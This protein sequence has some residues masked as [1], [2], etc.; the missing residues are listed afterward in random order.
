MKTM[1]KKRRFLAALSATLLILAALVTSCMDPLFDETSEQLGGN[2]TKAPA[3]KGLVRISIADTSERTIYPSSLPSLGDMYY[4]VQF[5]SDSGN[6]DDEIGDSTTAVSIGLLNGVSTPLAPDG[7]NILITAW[8]GDDP[9]SDKPLAGWTGY[10]TVASGASTLVTANLI[11][12]TTSGDGTFSYSITVPA[13]PSTWAITTPPTDYSTNKMEVINASNVTVNTVSLTKGTTV[14]GSI[15]SLTAG[16]YTVKITLTADDCQDRVV[17]NA[18]HIYNTMTSSY[19]YNV[20]ALNQDNFSVAFD[21]NGETDTGSSYTSTT[22]YPIAFLG[23]V[24]DPGDPESAVYDFDGWND[25]DDGSGTDWVFGGTGTKVLKDTTLYAQW[26]SKSGTVVSIKAI[27][28]VTAPVAGATPDTAITAT[29]EYTGTITWKETIT[30]TTVGTYFE[31]GKAY[32]ATITLS[33]ESGYIFAGVDANFFTVAGAT[34]VTNAANSGVVTAVFPATASTITNTA[35][36]GV[37]VPVAGATPVTTITDTQYTGVITWKETISGTVLT[38]DFEAGKAYTATITL[39]P[40]DGFTTYGLLADVFTVAGA[41]PVT[42]AANNG[43]VTA[44]FPTKITQSA[45]AGITPPKVGGVPTSTITATSEYTA[46]IS[47]LPTDDPF[48]AD[49]VYIATITITPKTGY[50]LNGVPANFFT[51]SG[52]VSTNAA[53]DGVVTSVFPVTT[54]GITMS[55]TFILN[56]MG[57]SSNIDS[58]TQAQITNGEKK[59]IFT[60]SGGPFDSNSVTWDMDGLS[61]SGGTDIGLTIDDTSNL[62]SKLN[63]GKHVLNV[64]GMIGTQEFSTNIEFTIY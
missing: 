18:M 48:I 8:E 25:K 3:G 13:L 49:V 6:N 5:T 15:P 35:I 45:I 38:G 4:T 12:W 37:T 30:G 23:T 58:A 41:T 55:I 28:G 1:I 32:T 54:S 19:S 20:P 10:A 11:G 47:W 64:K 26:K 16:Y 51:V 59:F 17:T 14:A 39:T 7:Y 40:E 52:A 21:L 2:N 60:I 50:T 44:V 63:I 27:P 61:A 34:P 43:V 29:T 24:N 36:S 42:N 33:A 57:I 31:A 56:D 53:N 62:L 22:Q 46:T 9:S